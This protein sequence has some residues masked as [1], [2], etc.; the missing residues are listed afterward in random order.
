MNSVQKLRQMVGEV[1]RTPPGPKLDEAWALVGRLLAR[2]P[3]DAAEAVRVC[4]QRDPAGLSALVARLE[5]ADAA[6][7]PAPS[8]TFSEDDLG[9]ALRAFK[10]RLRVSRLAEESK[11]GGRQLT[12]GRRSEIHAMIPPDDFPPEIWRALVA[13]GRLRDEGQGFYAL[14]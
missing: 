6:P 4:E 11:L 14:A 8:S 3:V 1:G 12:G 9:R 10:K 2:M 5:N 13:A 7:A